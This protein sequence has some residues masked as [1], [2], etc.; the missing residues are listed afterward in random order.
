MT[1]TLDMKN[2]EKQ[3]F[4][5]ADFEDGIWEIYLGLFFTMMS[6][7]PVTRELLG[8][9]LN[10]VLILGVTILLA[11]TALIAKKR[12]ILPRTALMKFGPKT[13]KK[14]KEANFITLGL[15]FA[16]FILVIFGAN[17]LIKTPASEL[18][19]Q[20]FSDFSIDLI[21][22]LITI[23]FFCLIAY[24]T[25][26]ACFYLYGVLIGASVLMKFLQEHPFPSKEIP[27]GR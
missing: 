7:F 15:V 6:F 14:V 5:I 27:D 17:S 10:A 18:L 23:G 16:T 1:Q 21:F 24:F 12:I 11:A 22:A 3:V 9:A 2:A 20:W 26:A 8:P 19:P 13:K 4:R 25:V